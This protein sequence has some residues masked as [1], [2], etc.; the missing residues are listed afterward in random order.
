MT[1][2]FRTPQMESEWQSRFLSLEQ[3][4]FNLEK[5]WQDAMVDNAGLEAENRAMKRRLMKWDEVG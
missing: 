3:D 1:S 2:V 5:D 4:Y